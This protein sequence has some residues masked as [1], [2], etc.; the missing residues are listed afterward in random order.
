MRQMRN[1]PKII[2]PE[3]LNCGEHS[4][5]SRPCCED[6]IQIDIS[7]I[8]EGVDWIRVICDVDQ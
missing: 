5:R 7:K 6:Y 3:T 4:G 8:V 2:C 1:L